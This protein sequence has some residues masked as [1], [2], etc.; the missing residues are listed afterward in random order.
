MTPETLARLVADAAE[1]KKAREVVVLDVRGKTT[2]A[3]YFVI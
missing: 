1:D 3:D 2:I